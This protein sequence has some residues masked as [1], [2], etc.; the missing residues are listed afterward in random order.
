MFGCLDVIINHG[1]ARRSRAQAEV[2]SQHLHH[3]LCSAD[4]CDDVG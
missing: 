1:E 2:D 4:G 3:A